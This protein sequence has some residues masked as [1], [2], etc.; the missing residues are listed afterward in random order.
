MRFHMLPESVLP[1]IAQHEQCLNEIMILSRQTI[2][3]KKIF[4]KLKRETK[5]NKSSTSIR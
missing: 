2:M 5:L 3:I 1:P 4:C